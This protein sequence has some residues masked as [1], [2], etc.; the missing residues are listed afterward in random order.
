[1]LDGD[2]YHREK[3]IR[4]VDSKCLEMREEVGPMHKRTRRGLAEKRGLE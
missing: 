2:N 1:M 4:E 3:L